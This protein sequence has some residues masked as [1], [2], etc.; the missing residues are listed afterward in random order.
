MTLQSLEQFIQD[1][2]MT[3]INYHQ[4]AHVMVSLLTIIIVPHP[5]HQPIAVQG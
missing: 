2:Q 4:V 3:I 1:E 5:H